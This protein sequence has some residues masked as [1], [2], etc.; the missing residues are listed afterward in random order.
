[1]TPSAYAKARR[2]NRTTICRQVKSGLIPRGADGLINVAEAD[3]A[4]ANNLDPSRGRRREAAVGASKRAPASGFENSS[5]YLSAR[6]RKEMAIAELRE[7]DAARIKGEYLLATEVKETW[8][9]AITSARSTILQWPARLAPRLIGISDVRQAEAIINQQVRELL[10]ELSQYTP[11]T[12]KG[13]AGP[14][15]QTVALPEVEPS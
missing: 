10:T 9:K 2:L 5:T 6:T 14:S 12:E 1:M 7:L 11:E 13:D 3:L 8:A 4:R 15:G